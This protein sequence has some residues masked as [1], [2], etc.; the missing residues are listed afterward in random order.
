MP[1]TVV[2]DEYK[3]KVSLNT[4]TKNEKTI[5]DSSILNS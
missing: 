3:L 1:M 5:T 4:M 2:V